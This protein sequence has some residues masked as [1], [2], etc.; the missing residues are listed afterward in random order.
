[1]TNVTVVFEYE[2][3]EYCRLCLSEET[4]NN[5]LATIG[6]EASIIPTISELLAIKLDSSDANAFICQTC[7]ESLEE[8]HNYRMRCRLNDAALKEKASER[9]RRQIELAKSAIENS[10]VLD[11]VSDGEPIKIVIRM[12]AE[13]KASMRLQV[14]SKPKEEPMET[15]NSPSETGKSSAGQQTLSNEKPSV[16]PE[17]KSSAN[18]KGSLSADPQKKI[19]DSSSP[20]NPSTQPSIPLKNDIHSPSSESGEGTNS[21]LIRLPSQPFYFYQANISNYGL[22]YGGYRYCGSVPR[23][24]RTLWFCEQRK[25]HRCSTVFLADRNYTSFFLTC[26]HNHDPPMVRQ[27][28]SIFKASAILK[29]VIEQDKVKELQSIQSVDQSKSIDRGSPQEI[30]SSEIEIKDED[31]SSEEESYEEDESSDD[32][33]EET[34]DVLD[35]ED[36]S[37]EDEKYEILPAAEMTENKPTVSNIK[38]D[39]GGN[40]YIIQELT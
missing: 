4:D 37:S 18:R 14:Q 16:F 21:N 34:H 19:S 5:E 36:N 29:D 27:N 3:P 31:T 6:S 15:A 32:E 28:V 7:L 8:F 33:E 35:I 20:A 38:V 1:M 23:K 25:S 10:N 26:G 40:M 22:I 30:L 39:D 12:N 17:R 9:K 11:Q 13:G 24:Q 2:E